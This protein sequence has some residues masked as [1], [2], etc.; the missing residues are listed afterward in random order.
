[1]AGELV[2]GKPVDAK[3]AGLGSGPGVEQVGIKVVFQPIGYLFAAVR[4]DM[5]AQLVC[6]F[7]AGFLPLALP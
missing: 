1:M 7:P 5:V 2:Q 3:L 6:Q 4:A